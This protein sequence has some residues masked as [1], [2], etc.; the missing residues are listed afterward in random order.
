MAYEL[1]PPPSNAQSGSFAWYDWYTKLRDYVLNIQIEDHN[2]LLNIQ[3]GTTNQYYHLTSAQ[4]TRINTSTQVSFTADTSLASL[5]S[6][7][8]EVINEATASTKYYL[9]ASF[10]LGAALSTTGFKIKV[11]APASSTVA[12]DIG[13]IPDVIST[14][15]TYHKRTTS[16][17]TY[18]DFTTTNMTSAST[19]MVH[20]VGYI[21]TNT[22]PGDILIWLSPSANTPTNLTIRSNSTIEASTVD[23]VS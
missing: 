12:L 16:N 15:A 6:A 22:T 9:R 20:I 18:V 1:P 8:W 2:D 4:H 10:C 21:L 7:R 14:S 19:A 5:S 23:V 17:D 13:V 3:G 11:A